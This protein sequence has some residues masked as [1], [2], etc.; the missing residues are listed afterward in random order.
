MGIHGEAGASLASI[1][2]CKDLVKTVCDQIVDYGY[3]PDGETKVK[4]GDKIALLVNNLGGA[5]VFEMYIIAR[6]AMEYWSDI[7]GPGNVSRCYVGSFM[8]SF[9]MHG[10][11]VTVLAM[12]EERRI[13]GW[14]DAETS[15]QAWQMAEDLA[16][17]GPA[18]PFQVR[19]SVQRNQGILEFSFL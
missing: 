7:V 2:P 18:E 19:K 17:A 5:S 12:D 10:A 6:D 11:S 3:G 13:E 8:T 14:L 4:R 15:C 16:K 9:N 1:T